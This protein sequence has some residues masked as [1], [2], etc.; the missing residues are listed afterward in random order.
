MS[1]TTTMHTTIE[2][3]LSYCELTGSG[4]QTHSWIGKELDCLIDLAVGQTLA[5]R[6]VLVSELGAGG[7]G[8]VYLAR[9][10][11]LER[12]VALKVRLASAPSSALGAPSIVQEGQL[13]ALVSH[14]SIA[15]VYDSGTHNGNPFTIFEYVDGRN[16]REA[17][18]QRGPQWPAEDV[19]S[20][21]RV[22]AEALDYA[23]SRGV[24]H[25]DL[26]P[27][28]ICLAATG[29]PKILDFG[30]ASR[31]NSGVRADRFKGTPAYA[32]PEQAE[33]KVLD[34]RSDQ[35]SLA[36]VVYE[37]L[38]GRRAFLEPDALRMLTAQIHNGAPP[39]DE[40]R[41]DLPAETACVVMRAL[42]KDP[43]DRFSTCREFATAFQRSISH[44]HNGTAFEQR[45][46][47]H[48]AE[49]QTESLV[50]KS[51][52]N[53]LEASGYRTWYYQRDALPGIPLSRQVR[54]SLQA[55]RV[56]L[57]LIS[58]ASVQSKAFLD[59]VVE[60]NLL[61][62]HFLPIL[63]DMSL[64]EFEGYRATWRAALGSATIIEY[65]R[66]NL[67][68]VL[69]RLLRSLQVMEVFPVEAKSFKKP[70]KA[71]EPHK[72]VTTQTWATDSNQIDIKDLQRV[73]FRNQVIENFLSRPNK[74][75]LSAT[76]GL[77]KTM[78]MK[79]KRH[80]MT[81]QVDGQ[82]VSCLIPSGQPYID[83]MGE[84]KLLSKNYDAQ[85]SDLSF[86]KRLWGMAL[87]ISILSHH[88]DAIPEMLRIELKAFP[89]RIQ[90]WLSGISVEPTV[91][92]KELTNLPV[93]EVN[94][95][96]DETEN[97]LDK[98]VRSVHASTMVFI[99]RVD[100]AV[101]HLSRDAWIHIQAG[102]I[103][104]AWDLMSS[105]SHVKVYAS[106]RQE[107]F[108]NFQ[109]D[110][111]ANLL[112]A[113][114]MLRYTDEDLR[115]LMNQLAE[116]YEGAEGFQ[117]F[118]GVNV[119]KH[120]SRPFPEDSFEFLKRFTFGRP[121]D[122]VAIAA[123]L[124]TSKES[125]DERRYCD[126]I[127]QTSALAL[128][129]S[130][131]DE[132][133][134]FLDCLFDR[135]NRMQFLGLLQTNIMTREQAIDIS[136]QFNGLPASSVYPLDEE[137]NEIFHPFRDLFLAGLLGVIRCND[138]DVSYQRF[139]RPEDALNTS[140]SDLPISSH[141]L[142]HP[143]L[144]EYIQ[145]AKPSNSYRVIQQILVGENAPWYSFDP[146]FLQIEL[147]LAKV[148]DLDVRAKVQEMLAE[149]KIA[150][151]SAKPHSL[152]AEMNSSRNW[153]ELVRG[154]AAGE[155]DDVVLWFDELMNC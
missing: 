77:G 101:R 39:I 155:Y 91:A 62:R 152:R 56:A 141:Y 69:D 138:Q 10:P 49:T 9:D 83:F 7:M 143:A 127:R 68:S 8:R 44:Q 125:L 135:D 33:C 4:L 124:S 113:T 136:R 87:R 27:E 31:V 18:K 73:V 35:Y 12:N 75:F 107:A 129:P 140:A 66:P 84:M 132:N 117:D 74:Y 116:C 93:G 131:F 5:G 51:L 6:Y 3:A 149:A 43:D 139:R 64:E 26:K 115:S 154:S 2:T 38:C 142:I 25:S 14:P 114:T 86:C 119:I 153:L 71:T 148:A 145:Q 42:A 47:I 112:G 46:D 110:I 82:Q 76:K 147:A 52:A 92:L 55:T 13:A 15:S 123:E 59:E 70:S 85:L 106:I 67:D 80:L 99:D 94:R 102:L 48:I 58:R 150:K 118:V 111:K 41:R 17:M 30:L 19:A 20:V 32:S 23:H 36:L 29:S 50:A 22:L 40:F 122:F 100:Q 97:F 34:G 21:L 72:A 1:R 81:N 60:A 78:L 89:Q 151:M 104:A 130:L 53:A 105:N 90:R 37:L 146:I 88:G 103:E 95:L 24:I 96:I 121:R 45:T 11:V 28:N 63:V 137:S 65:R 79:F 54:E 120:P 128:V 57:L 16:L 61:G 109:S 126:V 98:Q 144:S 134:V 108:A 133:K